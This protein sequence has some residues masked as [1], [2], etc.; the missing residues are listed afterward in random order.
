MLLHAGN[1]NL[2]DTFP[3]W[4][5]NLDQ[6]QL[7]NLRSNRF[8]G[9]IY[10]SDG[11]ISFARLRVVDLSHNNFSGNLPMKFFE[12]LHVIR[13]RYES[14]VKPEYMIFPSPDGVVWY[15]QDLSFTT[16][17]LETEFQFL[18]TIWMAIAFSRNNFFGEIPKTLGELHSL[19]MLNLSHH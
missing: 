16:K 17:G 13:E 15:A 11:T 2:N 8:H 3:N 18:L 14:K 7:L 4:L 12:N 19:I 6:L 9:E 1:N 10:I 5:G